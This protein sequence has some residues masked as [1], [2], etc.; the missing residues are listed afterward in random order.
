MAPFSG[1]LRAGTRQEMLPNRAGLKTLIK[2]GLQSLAPDLALV[3]LSIRSRRLIERQVRDLGL[4]GLGRCLAATSNSRVQSGPFA[5]MRLDLEALP[6]H[7]S[8]KLLGTYEDELHGCIEMAISRRPQLVLNVGCAEGYYAVGLATRLPGTIVY[9]F[10]ADP[11]A[12]R[13]TARNASLNGV[14]AQVRVSGVVHASGLERLLRL[15]RALVV[16]DCEG[17]EFE[18]L[19]PQAAPSLARADVIVEL[20]PHRCPAIEEK[21][22]ARFRSTHALERIAQTSTQLKLTHAHLPAILHAS[23]RHRVVDERRTPDVGWL[24]LRP[25]GDYAQTEHR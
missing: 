16:M 10:D 12:R 22:T 18:L 8:P 6:V 13:A 20:H 5:G 23:D 2:S 21:L 4:L 1:R 24:C 17:A 11:K 15:G 7:G 9:A 3:L 19:D 25:H 14:A